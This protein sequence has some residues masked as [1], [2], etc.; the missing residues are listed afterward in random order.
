[1][2]KWV[3]LILSLVLVGC[4]T[5]FVYNN[6]DWIV[7]EYV[8]DFVELTD[9]QETLISNTLE[10][11]TAWHKA[12]ELPNYIEHLNQLIEL[13]PSTL[14]L[15]DIQ[16]QETKLQAHTQRLLHHLAPD[17]LLLAKQLSDEQV[18]ELMDSI[19]VR[20]TR[21]KKK[22]QKLSEQEIRAHYG[23][24][25]TENIEDWLG[26]L[27][28]EQKQW[29]AEWTSE[30]YVTS[31]D[32]IDH[33]TKMRVEI[34]TLLSRRSDERYFVPH[35]EQLMFDPTSFYAQALQQK[36]DHNRATAHQYLV[37]IINSV[38]PKQTRHYRQELKD[39]RD[40]ALEI[41]N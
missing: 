8:D 30:L 11:L 16:Q 32:W 2:K 28:R 39:W 6:I 19:R 31:Y 24:K 13:D 18:E 15:D 36:I 25:L 10:R 38:S 1:M 35:F 17:I 33:Q 14:T 12:H 7:I 4:G 37:K 20:H 9:E 26:P 22:Y 5:K 34:S 41:H 29:I 27:S 23:K 21:Y 40:I 3:I